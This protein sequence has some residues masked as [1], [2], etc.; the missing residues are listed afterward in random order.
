MNNELNQEFLNSIKPQQELYTKKEICYRAYETLKEAEGWTNEMLNTF[1]DI[2]NIDMH[3]EIELEIVA[4]QDY[5]EKQREL[6]IINEIS[7]NEIHD[8]SES[9]NHR[10]HNE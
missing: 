9:N 1:K 7:M 6:H 4:H 8:L 3:D 10:N 2:L 5:I